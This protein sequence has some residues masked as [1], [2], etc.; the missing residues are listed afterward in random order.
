MSDS[1][2]VVQYIIWG[3][4]CIHHMRRRMHTSYEEEDAYI[5]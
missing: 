5:I 4:G 2:H 1:G 3:G